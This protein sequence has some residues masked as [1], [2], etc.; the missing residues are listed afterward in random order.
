MYITNCIS[1]HEC[2][3]KIF[4]IISSNPLIE[5]LDFMYSYVDQSDR[6]KLSK[7]KL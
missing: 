7:K 3:S 6:R 5:Y 1:I 2:I 4:M